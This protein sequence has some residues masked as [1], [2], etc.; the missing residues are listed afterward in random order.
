[1]LTQE[2]SGLRAVLEYTYIP[3]KSYKNRFEPKIQIKLKDPSIVYARAQ[4]E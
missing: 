2:N 4:T 3:L 1:M